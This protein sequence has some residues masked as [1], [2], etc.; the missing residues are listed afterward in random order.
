[1]DEIDNFFYKVRII[2]KSME[3]RE[4]QMKD[5]TITSI[6]L[7]NSFQGEIVPIKNQFLLKVKSLKVDAQN[8]S[9]SLKHF[10]T[11][12]GKYVKSFQE[13]DFTV[14]SSKSGANKNNDKSKPPNA[15][16][17]KNKKKQKQ[18]QKQQPKQVPSF[19]IRAYTLNINKTLSSTSELSPARLSR[20]NP[21]R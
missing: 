19:G 3:S 7:T 1:M 13:L 4:V 20:L 2:K 8:I 17:N 18:K 5:S 15:N 11:E 10:E 6:L 9:K 16:G 14:K 21:R 12:V